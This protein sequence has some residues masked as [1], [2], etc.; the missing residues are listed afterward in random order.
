MTGKKFALLAAGAAG[1]YLLV[2]ALPDLSQERAGCL[3]SQ[4]AIASV[5][6][7]PGGVTSLDCGSVTSNGVQSVVST[8][9]SR[10]SFGDIIRSQWVTTVRND[11]VE[12]LIQ[13]R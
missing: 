4:R 1:L 5:L 9:D 10:T 6:R 11:Q 12:M 13:V 3:A 7:A 2:M 8:V